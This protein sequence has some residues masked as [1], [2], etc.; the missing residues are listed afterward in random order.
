VTFRPQKSFLRFE[1]R[2]TRSDGIQERLESAGL[3]VMDYDDRWGR[4][5]IRLTPDDIKK[6]KEVLVQLMADTYKAAVE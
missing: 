6:H 1:P 5:R 3:D 2:L 4:Y